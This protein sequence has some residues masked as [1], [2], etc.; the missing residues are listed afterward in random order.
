MI[1]KHLALV[2]LLLVALGLVAAQIP[3]SI[4]VVV[5][6]PEAGRAL[7]ALQGG[8][9]FG[10]LARQ[11]SIDPT[12][13]S[14]GYMGILD[15]ANLRPELSAAVSGLAPGRL[16]AIGGFLRALPSSRCSI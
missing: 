9:D 3:I 1:V 2:A 11:V 7:A 15:P 12:A 14:G 5:T 6:L 10:S 8:A 4:L 13:S 16:S